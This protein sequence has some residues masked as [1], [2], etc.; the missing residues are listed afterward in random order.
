MKC[1]ARCKSNIFKQCSFT[2]NNSN[3]LCI[4]HCYKRNIKTIEE[5]LFTINQINNFFINI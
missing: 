2:S 4:K 1:I 3:K 5:E